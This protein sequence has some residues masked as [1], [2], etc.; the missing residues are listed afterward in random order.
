MYWVYYFE[1][2]EYNLVLVL[3]YV[4]SIKVCCVTILFFFG[5]SELGNNSCD[6]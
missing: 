1:N 6:F 4:R 2:I 3:V 5:G